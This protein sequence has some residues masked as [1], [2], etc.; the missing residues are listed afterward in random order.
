MSGPAPKGRQALVFSA[1]P[2]VGLLESIRLADFSESIRGLDRSIMVH[3]KYVDHMIEQ[4]NL[5]EHAARVVAD[6][7][8][9]G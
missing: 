1:R 9:L 8:E 4:M 3:L 2:L 5:E 7:P 6:H